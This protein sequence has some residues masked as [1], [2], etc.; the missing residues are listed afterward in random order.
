MQQRIVAVT[1]MIVQ[2]GHWGM[3][4]GWGNC[5][6]KLSS[7]HRVLFSLFSHFDAGHGS[8]GP[9][10]QTPR[11]HPRFHQFHRSVCPEIWGQR[12]RSCTQWCSVRNK[13]LTVWDSGF[14]TFWMGLGFQERNSRGKHSAANAR[15]MFAWNQKN[16]RHDRRT[17]AC[18]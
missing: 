7:Q 12:S 2:A 5:V 11:F 10:R 17:V 1:G 3:K 8:D 13:T 6:V 18:V 9:C 15:W 4:M 16:A 14:K